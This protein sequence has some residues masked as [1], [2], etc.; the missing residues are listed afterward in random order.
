MKRILHR[1]NTDIDWQKLK[2]FSLPTNSSLIVEEFKPIYHCTQFP[3][4]AVCFNRVHPSRKI[5]AEQTPDPVKGIVVRCPECQRLSADGDERSTEFY[6][7]RYVMACK[8]GHLG[9]VEWPFEV[10]RSGS[11]SCRGQVFEWIASGSNDNIEIVC[12]GHWDGD[13]NNFQPSNCNLSTTYLELKGRSKNGQMDCS[14]KF[15]ETGQH[16]PNGCPRVNEQ[17]QAK[18]ISKTQM[19]IRMPVI[20]TTM[21]IQKYKGI[22]FNLFSPLA[23]SIVTAISFLEEI[24]PDWNKDD[25]I[26]LY[27]EK[28][29]GKVKGITNQMIRQTKNASESIFHDVIEAIRIFAKTLDDKQESLTEY[30]SLKEELQSLENQTRDRGVGAQIGP[31]DPPTDIRFPIKFPTP[32][33]LDFEAMPFGDIKVTQVQSGYTREV[34]PPAPTGGDTQQEELND[35]RRI[36]DVVSHSEVFNDENGSRWYLGNQLRGE[37]IFIHLDPEKH[38]DALELFKTLD[39][40]LKKWQSIHQRTVERNQ[41]FIDQLRSQEGKEQHVD[42]LEQENIQTNPL[43]VWWHSFAHEL[44]NQLSIDSGFMGVAL[45]ERIYCIKKPNGIFAAGVFIYASSPGADGTLGG[46]TSLVNSEVLPMIVE[47]TL[48]KIQTCSNDPICSDRTINVK[49]RTGAA[50]HVCLMN[51][52][53]SCAY[54]NQ[55]LDRN[56]VRGTL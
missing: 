39:F 38:K 26:K 14:A 43:F 3:K 32:M 46:L 20:T 47:R 6:S 54:R 28:N 23:P 33:N 21:E 5:L 17:S 7:A 13:T 45:G 18:M 25:F 16:D 41:P 40:N 10:H 50:C 29:K 24:K 51:S 44:I 30:E 36:G 55:Y 56:V 19:S 15:A 4:W 27:L 49:R 2:L 48:Y 22:L 31:D 34:S 35:G 8:R 52:E 53:T 9:D 11:V 42:A 1:F 12:L 37:G